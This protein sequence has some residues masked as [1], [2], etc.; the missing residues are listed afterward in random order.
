MAIWELRCGSANDF[1]A[2]VSRDYDDIEDEL[3]DTDGSP[4]D[5][6]DRP[7]VGYAVDKRKKDQ[8][9]RADI[10]QLLP[11]A[12]VLGERAREALGPF[13]S[14]FGQLLEL[15]C[16]GEPRWFFNATNIV[17]CVDKERSEK[18]E[19][20]G[21]ALEAFDES[22]APNHATL[23]KDPLTAP[24]RIYVNDAAKEVVERIVADAGLT[25]IECGHPRRF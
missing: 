11:G 3:F 10:G 21:I 7:L 23:F 15:D 13:L 5:W 2:I 20:G 9:P 1:A 16:E 14:R 24:V 25:G 17:A 4:K 6:K 12:L 22:K 8:K 18:L 19:D